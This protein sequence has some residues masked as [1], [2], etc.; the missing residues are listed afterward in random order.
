[1]TSSLNII[2][3]IIDFAVNS[4]INHIDNSIKAMNAKREEE[5]RHEYLRRNS[6]DAEYKVIEQ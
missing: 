4:Y 2:K 1:M 3:P 6:I 5:K